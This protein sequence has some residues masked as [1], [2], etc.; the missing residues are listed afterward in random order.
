MSSLVPLQ[1]KD[2]KWILFSTMSNEVELWNAKNI[3]DIKLS[4]FRKLNDYLVVSK[5]KRSNEF[6][7]NNGIP[8]LL[9]VLRE[10]FPLLGLKLVKEYS[11][12]ELLLINHSIKE[13]YK[14]EQENDSQMFLK[15]NEKSKS[16]ESWN[17]SKIN[18]FLIFPNEFIMF[19]LSSH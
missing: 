10:E 15:L 19:K 5:T 18:I 3:Y 13:F 7:Y 17:E 11:K 9:G 4:L 12:K 16:I 1:S 6:I 8:L 14:K 2:S